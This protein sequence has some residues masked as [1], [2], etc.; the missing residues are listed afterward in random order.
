MRKFEFQNDQYYHIYNRGVDKREIFI[1]DKDYYRF[2]W[3]LRILNNLSTKEERDFLKR[4]ALKKGP[5]SGYPE[6]GLNNKFALLVK[7]LNKLVSIISFCLLSNHFHLLLKQ[8]QEK[9]ISKFIQKI[10]L[11]YTNYFNIK[12]NRSGVLFQGRFK[13][14]FIKTDE[15]LLWLSGYINGNPEIHGISKARRWQWS[16]CK[17]YVGIRNGTI[18]DKDV[19]LSQFDDSSDYNEYVKMIIS[20]AR[21]KKEDVNRYLLE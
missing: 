21:E 10:T 18:C 17:D 11:A 5:G 3:N 4:Q 7:D 19:I 9:G 15:R 2:L 12:N 13:V 20:D 14:A 1:D 8:K 6:P 16:S